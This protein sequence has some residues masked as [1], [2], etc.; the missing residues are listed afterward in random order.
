M[1]KPEAHRNACYLSKAATQLA[2][3]KPSTEMAAE[4]AWGFKQV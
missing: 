4:E 2:M 1:F 3:G